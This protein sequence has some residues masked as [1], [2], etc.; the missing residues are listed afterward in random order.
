[1]LMAEKF[2][3]LKTNSFACCT[4]LILQL[5]LNV[6]VIWKVNI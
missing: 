2:L 6:F 3:Q 5:S 4:I 1:M